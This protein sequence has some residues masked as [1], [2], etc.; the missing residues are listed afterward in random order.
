[1][2]DGGD[3]MCCQCEMRLSAYCKD[4]A[5]VD[6]AQRFANNKIHPSDSLESFDRRSLQAVSVR[7]SS[8]RYTN[9]YFL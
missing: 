3:N 6:I 5:N 1:M 8:A 7:R 9:S 4:C 2:V